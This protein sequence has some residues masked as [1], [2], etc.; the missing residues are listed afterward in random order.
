MARSRGRGIEFLDVLPEDGERRL[1]LAV[2]MDAVQSFNRYRSR[3]T[4]GSEYHE[5]RRERTWFQANDWSNPFSFLSICAALGLNADYVRRCVL[6][7]SPGD[8][9][10]RIRRYAAK[11]EEAW[12]RQR[13]ARPAPARRSSDAVTTPRAS[14]PIDACAFE[15]AGT[16]YCV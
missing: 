4:H 16:R 8:R 7:C 5:W 14:S 13:R 11:T 3:V 6:R 9:P 1:M 12:A 15:S 10:V 2:L